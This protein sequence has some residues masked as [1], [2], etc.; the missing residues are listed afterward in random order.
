MAFSFY[1][2]GFSL[3]EWMLCGGR[4]VKIQELTPSPLV[5]EDCPRTS[6]WVM[7]INVAACSRPSSEPHSFWNCRRGSLGPVLCPCFPN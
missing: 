5:I 2:A 7:L 4:D 1:I 6:S 3:T